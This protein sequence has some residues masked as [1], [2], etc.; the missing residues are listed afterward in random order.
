MRLPKKITK[1]WAQRRE[2]CPKEVAKFLEHWP[3]GADL[4]RANLLEAA[5]LDFHEETVGWFG[6][7]VLDGEDWWDFSEKEDRAADRFWRTK[8]G[9]GPRRTYLRA[10][11]V[12]LADALR[13]P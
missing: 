1:R 4:T 12:A 6:D 9:R 8:R 5:E 3:E 11:A 10:C 2:A 7:H 13:L